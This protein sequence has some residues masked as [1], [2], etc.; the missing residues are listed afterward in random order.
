M[1][2]F[3][4]MD[5]LGLAGLVKQRAASPRDLLDHAIQ[6]AAQVNPTINAV[7]TQMHEQ[8]YA[9]IEAGLPEGPLSGVPF[10]LKDLRAQYGGVA[11]THGSRMFRDD[12]AERDSELV[13][14][15]KAAGV[16]I[17]GKTNTSEFGCCP[18]TEGGYFGT[19]R[20]PWDTS[21]SAGGSSG[22]SAAAVAARVVP[23]AHGSDGGGSIRIPAACCGVFGFKPSRGVNPA[24]PDYGE[25]WNGLSVEHALTR[26]VRDS[27]AILDATRGA[28][29]GDPYCGPTFERSLLA[30]CARPPGR[31]R[32]AVQRTA[33]SGA[34]V[35][36]E[37]IK[38]VD[39]GARLLESLGHTVEE[40]APSYDHERVSAAFA[41]AIAANV[42][43]A[44][45][46]L[47]EKTGR[48]PDLAEVGNVIGVLAAIG[49][50]KTA[51]DMA[52]AV[53][54]L[55]RAGRAVGPF[56]EQY[57]A[58]LSPVVATPPPKLGTLDTTSHDIQAYLGAVF[59]FIPFT[60]LS[61]I[62]GIPS[63]AVPIHWRGD[64]VPIGI[65]FTAGYGRDGQ[66]F[67]LAAQLEAASPWAHRKPALIS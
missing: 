25:A 15:L 2:E 36:P 63:M 3:D 8:A 5:A 51:A 10:L 52:R 29:S 64:G 12:V 43:G 26:S 17:F 27:A 58:L 11:T 33:L 31:L 61:N 4:D 38:A 32:I 22:G 39:A 66:L 56:F 48:T 37:C 28:A 53:W 13:R 45:D 6:R 16:V 35:D 7:V 9:E 46:Q 54:T 47:G 60:A 67:S 57:D 55:H 62:A 44:I 49:H 42:Q 34:P 41:L 59:R 24:G 65:H 21:L 1:T 50:Q 19:T 18:S 20:N 23:A 30:E 14:R 40:A